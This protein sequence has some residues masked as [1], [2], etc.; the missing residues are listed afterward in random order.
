MN[1]FPTGNGDR[2]HTGDPVKLELFEK[3]QQR[4]RMSAEGPCITCG[5]FK[6]IC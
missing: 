1:A 5:S 3:S 6:A 4:E 2:V